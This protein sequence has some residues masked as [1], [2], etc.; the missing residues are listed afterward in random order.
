[1]CWWVLT[2]GYY[3][4]AQGNKQRHLSHVSKSSGRLLE[5][6]SVFHINFTAGFYEALGN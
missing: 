3:P 2:V 5:G 4:L 6:N 1:M